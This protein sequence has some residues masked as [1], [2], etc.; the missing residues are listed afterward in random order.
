MGWKVG[1]WVQKF[2]ET[3][4]AHTKAL[5][6][7]RFFSHLCTV[8][9]ERA[10]F[11]HRHFRPVKIWANSEFPSSPIRRRRKTPLAKGTTSALPL[12]NIKP[13]AFCKTAHKKTRF[14]SSFNPLMRWLVHC[15]IWDSEQGPGRAAAPPSPVL[16]VPNE[17]IHP[18]MTSVPTSYYST[19]HYNW[20]CSLLVPIKGLSWPYR[21]PLSTNG[22]NWK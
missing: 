9:I 12:I 5:R 16:A 17:T 18:S 8:Q 6:G 4:F 1:V 21:I 14:W 3:S 19:W 7:W 2:M 15:Y 13:K 22:R 10:V 20:Q 11:V